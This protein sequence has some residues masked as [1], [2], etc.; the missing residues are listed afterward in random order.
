MKTVCPHCFGSGLVINQARLG[1]QMRQLR[2]QAGMQAQ[3]MAKRLK[4]SDAYI[5]R[6]EA[7]TRNW[8]KPFADA[9]RAQLEKS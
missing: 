9:Y 8:S 4:V 2:Q 6:L 7:G 1:Q 3:E 5:C